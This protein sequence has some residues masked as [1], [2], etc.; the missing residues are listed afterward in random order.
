MN[1]KTLFSFSASFAAVCLIAFGLTA[2]G[3]GKKDGSNASMHAPVP[4]GPMYST[5]D[6][7]NVRANPNPDDPPVARLALHQKVTALGAASS[8]NVT[9]F[10][11]GTYYTA[12]F[13]KVTLENGVTGWVFASCLSS[14]PEAKINY[15]KYDENLAVKPAGTATLDGR[16]V[17]V[18]AYG[19][20]LIDDPDF[21]LRMVRKADT[22]ND[23]DL[24]KRLCFGDIKLV[25][26]TPSD[27]FGDDYTKPHVTRRALSSLISYLS[28]YEKDSNT[29]QQIYENSGLGEGGPILGCLQNADKT[30]TYYFFDGFW[31]LND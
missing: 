29:T 4:N 27:L 24:F 15:A 20:Y 23:L 28:M 17:G 6:G 16:T 30:E 26:V 5:L 19:E 13:L 21:F 9:Y 7:V 18:N 1:P 14:N 12:P 2:V 31:Q 22:D 25:D 8:S 11:R 10:L 3:C